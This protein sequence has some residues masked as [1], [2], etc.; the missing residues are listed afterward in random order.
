V[1]STRILASWNFLLLDELGVLAMTGQDVWFVDSTIP[2]DIIV[3]HPKPVAI[4]HLVSRDGG[5]W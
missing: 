1:Q 5:T 2:A 3:K 4:D